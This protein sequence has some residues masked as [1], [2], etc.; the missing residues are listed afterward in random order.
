[1]KKKK[2]LFW[3]N[4]KGTGSCKLLLKMIWCDDDVVAA[5]TIVRVQMKKKAVLKKE[6]KWDDKD[7][8]DK[9]TFFGWNKTLLV[10]RDKAAKSELSLS[11][12]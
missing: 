7:K 4:D 2:N 3:R 8:D 1:M 6:R 10:L 12:R 11:Q 9:F 5:H